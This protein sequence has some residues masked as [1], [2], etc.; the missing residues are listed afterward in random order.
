LSTRQN[1]DFTERVGRAQILDRLDQLTARINTFVDE[2]AANQREYE[3][4][5]NAHGVAIA[6]Y[7]RL[8]SKLVALDSERAPVKA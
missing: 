3:E 6:E 5:S 7:D 4:L 1:T 2:L 8:R